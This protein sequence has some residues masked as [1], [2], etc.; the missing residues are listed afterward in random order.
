MRKYRLLFVFMIF[1]IVFSGLFLAVPTEASDL[2]V[3]FPNGGEK[4]LAGSIQEI[5][6]DGYEG[7][8]LEIYLSTNS[9]KNYDIYIGSGSAGSFTWAVPD[10]S[11][12]QARIKVTGLI[13]Y[14]TRY[15]EPF[16]VEDTSDS[17]FSIGRLPAAP[18]DLTA[19]ALSASE[20][21]LAWT[22]KADNETGFAIERDQHEIA[23]VGADT[24]TATH[25]GLPP[26]TLYSYRVRA[27]NAFGYSDYS[28]TVRVATL[29]EEP[30][31]TFLEAP[32]GL[33]AEALSA[34]EILLTWTDNANDEEGFKIYRDGDIVAA[35]NADVETFTD[36]GLEAGTN[37]TY[38]VRAYS[39]TTKS[40]HSTEASATT[41][42]ADPD[43]PLPALSEVIIRLQIDSTEY[44]VNDSTKIMDASPTIREGRTLLPIRYVAEPL[45]AN[46]AWDNAERKATISLGETVVELWIGKNRARVNGSYQYIDYSNH[47]V[48]PIIVP[49]GR[50]MLPLRFIA[51]ALNCQVDWDALNREVTVT[52]DPRLDPK[53]IGELPVLPAACF[54][55]VID[56]EDL[57][58]GAKLFHQYGTLGVSFPHAPSIIE[59]SDIGT[60]SGTKALSTYSPGA[61]FGGTLV[62]E[63]TTGQ[64]CVSVSVG[65]LEDSGGNNVLATLEAFDERMVVI[66]GHGVSQY[67]G[68]KVAVQQRS[69]GPGPADIGTMMAVQ[70][71]ESQIYRV[72]L[73]FEGGYAP[74][75]D[76]LSFSDVGEPF[77]VSDS[78][79]RVIIET[80]QDG[81]HISGFANLSGVFDLKGT[82]QVEFKLEEVAVTVQQGDQVREGFLPFSGNAPYYTF[83]GPNIH[84]LIFP[85]EN[86]ITV[87]AKS[88]SGNS[89]SSSVRVYYEPLVVGVEAELLILTPG[90][91]YASLESLRDWK[92]DTGVPSHIMTLEAIEQDWRFSGSRD[93][94]EKVKKAIAHAYELHG[95]RYVMLVG[96]GDR[97]PVRYHKTGREGVSWGVVYYITDLYY[98]CLFKSDGTFDNWDGNDNGIIG[99]WWAPLVEGD[100]AENFDQINIDNCSLKPD[101]AV[102]RVPASSAYEV[103]AYVNKVIAY[104]IEEAGVSMPW[105][106][107][108]ENIVLWSG[109][110]PY[111][112]DENDLEY[113]A[114]ELLSDFTAKKHYRSA[115]NQNLHNWR[116]GLIN[117]INTG[118]FFAIFFGHGGRETI[119]GILNSSDAIDLHNYR[120][121][122]VFIACACDTAKFVYEWDIYKA[123]FAQ[124]WDPYKAGDAKYPPCWPD[125]DKEG[126]PD[127]RPEPAA[128]QPSEIDVQSMAEA[129]LFVP[130][131]GGIGYLG[132]HTGTNVAGPALVKL[133]I[134]SW[135]REDVERLGDMWTAGVHDFVEQYLESGHWFSRC[136]FMSRHI[137]KFV[138]FGDPS[139]RFPKNKQ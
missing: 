139:L 69:I 2:T 131:A 74:V 18:T 11:T 22:D 64:T 76:D 13:E 100:A 129:L 116:E 119:G 80:P 20:I 81:G 29:P 105:E 36:S 109:Q 41:H 34:S 102:G 14:F 126:W 48:M 25:S 65:L 138:L 63:F 107:W 110:D 51:E 127:P 62:V 128:I 120:R 15:Q 98:A 12:D 9:G 59:P 82:I 45:G 50:T 57:D 111:P 31:L 134:G 70:T 39:E 38:S 132:A 72:E 32:S 21:L 1:S 52:R 43:Q 68:K 71:D 7:H 108:L 44:Y 37:Y 87:T 130:E 90:D 125:C 28:N 58:T 99:E 117:D 137:H 114:S 104:E 92:N 26:S 67:P 61:E 6:W 54:Q 122:P 30:D 33:V 60:S 47:D 118:A 95:T 86:L 112:H 135:N 94:S 24:E 113:V 17:D 55:H 78:V 85:G 49:P 79:P 46:V 136:D 101:V 10:I 77:S 121:Y 42:P 133:F 84:N 93:L 96:D 19:V 75:I 23:T 97:F 35:V 91:F 124:E 123:R 16:I 40:D 88:F 66:P 56:F 8:E 106:S 5:N 27:F 83:G 53:I 4:L 103:S 3:T 89:G 73:S 115:K